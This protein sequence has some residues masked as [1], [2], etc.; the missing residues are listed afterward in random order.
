MPSIEWNHVILALVAAH[1]DGDE[2][3][4][5]DNARELARLYDEAGKPELA[6]HVIAQYCP[7]IAF[8]PM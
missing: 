8:V 7:E 2:K 3:R 4:F 6:E 1:Y 5:K